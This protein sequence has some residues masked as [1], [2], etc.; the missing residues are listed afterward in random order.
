M[1][2][3]NKKNKDS[4]CCVCREPIADDEYGLDDLLKCKRDHPQRAHPLCA[5]RSWDARN[6]IAGTCLVSG[7]LMGTYPRDAH[8][9]RFD[10]NAEF[11]RAERDCAEEEAICSRRSWLKN[12]FVPIAVAVLLLSATLSIVYANGGVIKGWTIVVC[13]SL[14]SAGCAICCMILTSHN[15]KPSSGIENMTLLYLLNAASS[16]DARRRHVVAAC[17][18]TWAG[19]VAARRALWFE[20]DK[21]ARESGVSRPCVGGK[22]WTPIRS[23]RGDSGVKTPDRPTRTK[24]LALAITWDRSSRLLERARRV[25]SYAGWKKM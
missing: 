1:K 5:I 13:L 16:S 21:I 17:A 15:T 25:M 10:H 14:L 20:I 4:Q 7:C 12:V 11:A 19:M 22:D 2:T 23:G 6:V 3:S 8:P 24:L 9:D 18:R